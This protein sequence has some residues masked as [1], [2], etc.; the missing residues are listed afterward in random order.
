MSTAL[1]TPLLVRVRDTSGNP[2]VGT[3]VVF[4]IASGGGSV[5]PAIAVTD[6]N[7]RAQAAW[8]LGSFAGPQ[9]VT[10]TVGAKSVT[11]TASG[12]LAGGGGGGGGGGVVL[13]P[14]QL[15]LVSGNGQNGSVGQTLGSSIV[16]QV[17]DASGIP[18]SGV[19]VTWTLAAGNSGGF[20][21]PTVSRTDGSGNASLLWTL[22]SK[23]GL[24]QVTASATGVPSI[25][26]QATAQIGSSGALLIDSGDGQV[27]GTGTVLAKYLRVLVLDQ[28]GTPVVGARVVWS[29]ATGNGTLS[30][31]SGLSN[32]AGLDS[33]AWTFG[34]TVGAQ[35]ATATVA[36]LSPVAFRGTASTAAGPGSTPTSVVKISGDGQS[37]ISGK[38]LPIPLVVEVRDASG[39][40]LASVPVAFATASGGFLSPA[41]ATTGVDGRASTA[42]TLSSNAGTT[43]TT[44]V[45]SVTVG[46]LAP[47]T[48]SATV[49]P[50]LRVQWIKG[51][52]SAVSPLMVDTTGA[53]LSDTLE[54]QVYDP[55]GGFFLGVAGQSV[56][57]STLA[58]PKIDGLPVN[59]VV[60]TDNNG[61]A[62]NRW[63]LRSPTGE[64]IPPSNI[65]K[66][67]KARAT[68]PDGTAIGE[69]EFQARVH[70]GRLCS[71]IQNSSPSKPVVGTNVADTVTVKDCNGF[72]VPSATV[73]FTVQ[74]PGSESVS[75]AATTTNT[76][77]QAFTTWTV[78]T[79]PVVRSLSALASGKATPY[80]AVGDPTYT[81]S[82]SRVETLAAGSPA[83]PLIVNGVPA[84]PLPTGSSYTVTIVVKD[85]YN[86]VVPTQTVN[87]VASGGGVLP[88]TPGSVSSASGTTGTDGSVSVVWTLGS[89]PVSNT[90]TITA[91]GVVFSISRTGF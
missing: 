65:A 86:N 80:T 75:P 84:G 81:V 16:V 76:N 42:W 11:F 14:T 5:T 12:A 40:P 89:A 10:A 61:R 38:T 23:V 68:M 49:R 32:A 35:Q 66:R 72:V 22:G 63:V 79:V 56:G 53:T 85:K 82:G 59:S 41:N 54:V 48:F 30:K 58:D 62:K 77:G 47:V 45:A 91:G 27:A 37:A 6:L 43:V 64:G 20:A 51:G 78:D 44:D 28:S 74:S 71:V 34:A 87:F 60:V 24:Q 4:A 83:T 31:A 88:A 52:T 8:T 3:S 13:T 39:T 7:G 17:I 15:V 2:V 26:L 36:G 33:A 73:T 69:V 19:N 29:T 67:M 1:G 50:A 9:T 18:V 90:L 21:S 46:A 70:P 57:W 55:T 25:A